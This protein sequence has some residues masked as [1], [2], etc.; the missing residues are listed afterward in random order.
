MTPPAEGGFLFSMFLRD[1][2]DVF[3]AY[4]TTRR[5]VDRLLFSNNV[6][7]LSAYGRQE[8]WEDS[9]AGWPQHPTYG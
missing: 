3:R 2:D 7:D 4:S 9:P 5:G 8:D 6:K 1:G